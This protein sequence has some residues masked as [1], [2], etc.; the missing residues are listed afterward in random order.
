MYIHL[1]VSKNECKQNLSTKAVNAEPVALE[2][3]L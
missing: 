3:G 1:F 2:A